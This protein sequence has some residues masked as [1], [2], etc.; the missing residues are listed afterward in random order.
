LGTFRGGQNLVQIQRKQLNFIG[1]SGFCFFFMKYAASPYQESSQ[2]MTATTRVSTSWVYKLGSALAAFSLWGGWAWY[3]NGADTEWATYL[4]AIAQGT[5]S[6]FITLVLVSLVTRL[7]NG[8]RHPLARLL[9]PSLLVAGLSSSMLVLVHL[10]V[11][12]QHL[13]P[14][15]VPPSTVAFL[16]CLFTT[17]KL[18]RTD[19]TGIC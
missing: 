7:Y 2:E 3:V 12:T 1:L 18:F 17:A 10:L 19:N 11:G 8:L 5:S 4:T 15:I 9:L 14:T 13:L 6:F 16:F